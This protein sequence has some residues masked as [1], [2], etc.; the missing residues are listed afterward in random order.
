MFAK[1]NGAVPIAAILAIAAALA[2]PQCADA[3]TV[4]N[5][6]TNGLGSVATSA[7]MGESITVP[8][9]PDTQLDSF[10]FYGMGSGSSVEF[11]ALVYQFNPA[12]MTTVGLPLYTSSLQVAPHDTLQTLAFATGPLNLPPG[13]RYLLDLHQQGYGNAGNL[14]I[15]DSAMSY[16]G[17]QFLVY[18]SYYGDWTT[19]DG[20]SP[21]SLAFQAV[22]NPTPEPSTL[23]LLCSALLGLGAVYLRR[24]GAK[25]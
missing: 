14:Q 7:D 6:P 23:A 18:S 10:Q 24:R 5:L 8:T 19:I 9:G 16:S 12:T 11:E 13:G 2:A 17:G 25:A 20:G 15:D 3:Q 21:Q 22:F 4:I 1:R